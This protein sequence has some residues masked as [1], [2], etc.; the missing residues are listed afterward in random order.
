MCNAVNELFADQI[1]EMKLI[2]A[3]KDSMLA[4]K[5]SMLADKDSQIARQNALIAQLQAQLEEYAHAEKH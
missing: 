4:D 3:D 2:I 5:D 1:E